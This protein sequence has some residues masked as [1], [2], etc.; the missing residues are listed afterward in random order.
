M[1]IAGDALSKNKSIERLRYCIFIRV[2]G[3]A[4]YVMFLVQMAVCTRFRHD[5]VT[6]S[7]KF[8]PFI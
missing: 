5:S 6:C 7:P 2:N 3:N 1:T 8:Y 4:L